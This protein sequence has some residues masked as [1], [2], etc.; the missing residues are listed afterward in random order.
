M[1]SLLT[2]K[3][4]ICIDYSHIYLLC[5]YRT[6][7]V[8]HDN[9]SDED[10]AVSNINNNKYFP[11]RWRSLTRTYALVF[12]DATQI[13]EWRLPAVN[14][15]VPRICS[16]WVEISGIFHMM[17]TSPLVQT[18][19]YLRVGSVY[20]GLKNARYHFTKVLILY[21]SNILVVS[22]PVWDTCTD[23]NSVRLSVFMHL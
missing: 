14:H 4:K 17:I 3:F 12:I 20:E 18:D 9:F 22:S 5:E 23:E 8:F 21:A 10:I 6:D 2:Y 11:C 16:L 1:S 15:I 7:Y 13:P 19:K